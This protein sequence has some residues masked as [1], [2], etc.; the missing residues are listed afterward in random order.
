MVR[1]VLVALLATMIVG[2][3]TNSVKLR[4]ETVEVVRPILYCPAP[5][6]EELNRPDA[7]PIDSIT[8]ETPVGEVAVRY[9]ATVKI[10]QNYIKRL[11]L[12]LDQYD[13]T[14][15]AYEELRKQFENN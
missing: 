3:G 9:K 10:L 7:L 13:N 2:C 15:A 12:S 14:N 4:T 6:R 8:S 5:N 1:V 11:E